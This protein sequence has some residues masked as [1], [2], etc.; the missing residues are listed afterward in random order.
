MHDKQAKKE[1]RNKNVFL[2]FLS[3][4]KFFNFVF[5]IFFMP[6]KRYKTRAHIYNLIQYSKMVQCFWKAIWKYLLKVIN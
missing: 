4:C 3:Y 5:N 6:A 1:N 2:F